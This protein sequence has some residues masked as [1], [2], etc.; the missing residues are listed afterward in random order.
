MN[1][2][3]PP[4][5]PA[6]TP[7]ALLHGGEH[8][9]ITTINGTTQRVLVQQIPVKMWQEAL[10]VAFNEPEML[11]LVCAQEPGWHG[12]LTP[13]SYGIL[14][15][16]CRRQNEDFFASAEARVEMMAKIPGF[17]DRILPRATASRAGFSG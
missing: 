11:E 8:V 5:D 14:R 1:T 7:H 17:L 16:A 6:N 10:G 15:A 2:T 12:T 4:N 13:K 9:D 3:Q